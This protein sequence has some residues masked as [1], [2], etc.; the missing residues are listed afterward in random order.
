MR[1]LAWLHCSA[2][3][4][5]ALILS[6]TAPVCADE[7]K[8]KAQELLTEGNALAREG[9]FGAA[10]TKFRTA[11]E[12]Y[13]SPK[14]LLNIGT[15]LR[16]T[17]RYA[18][19][20]ETYEA[21]LA[22]PDAEPARTREVEGLVDELDQLVG[23][24]EVT[25]SDPDARVSLDGH[26]LRKLGRELRVDPG[27]H[28]LVA[29]KAGREPTV[30]HFSVG[31][32]QLARVD[33]II[34]EPGEPPPEPTPVRA[35]VG[36]GVA[37]LGGAAMIVGGIIGA[38]ALSTK[39]DADDHCAESGPFAGYCNAEGTELSDEARAQGVAATTVFILGFAT[40]ATGL[41]VAITAPDPNE[42]VQVSIG[43]GSVRVRF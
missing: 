3:I 34:A 20:A 8:Q 35:I 16:H 27:R 37:G 39:G 31:P 2:L 24:L 25:V 5:S 26:T 15:S 1:R 7:L 9:D 6:A 30:R 42:D 40:F 36:Y 17:G 23:R 21:Y 32:K 10:L 33:L 18:E 12:L 43:P 19:A 13:P 29:E 22:H 4:V 14:L 41:A 11:Y 38:V 28:T